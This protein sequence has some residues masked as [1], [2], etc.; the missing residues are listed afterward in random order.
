MKGPDDGERRAGCRPPVP[1]RPK[2]QARSTECSHTL[3]TGAGPRRAATSWSARY[4]APADAATLD[5]FKTSELVALV[6]HAMAF[7]QEKPVGAPKV[8]VRPLSGDTRRAR[9]PQRGHAVPAR[10]RL[11]RVARARPHDRPRPASADQDRRTA[12]GTLV[13]IAG[14]GDRSWSDGRQESYIAV[15]L[16]AC[17]PAR[18]RTIAGV[19][20]RHPRRC[21]H[22]RR[23][24]EAHAR[25]PAQG[26]QR[27]RGGAGQRSRSHERNEAIAF[28]EWLEAGNITLLG[29]RDYRLDGDMQTGELA[30]DRC[31]GPWPARRIQR[32]RC[33]AA[34]P[35]FVAMTPEVRRFFFEPAP[36]IIT[37][38]NVVSRIHRRVHMDY[39]GVKTLRRRRAS[40]R[41]SCASSA[42]SRRTAYTQS[43]RRDS[44]SCGTRSRAC[45]QRVGSSAES[46]AGKALINVLETFPRDEL[47]QISAG[48]LAPLDGG[49]PRS[50]AEAARA[51][52]CRAS[53][54]STASSRCCCSCRATATA[55]SVRE[56]IGDYLAEA[57]KG[58]VTAFFP[59]FHG[60]AAGA[61]PVHHRT[62]RGRR[63]RASMSRQ[64]ERGIAGIVRTWSDQLAELLAASW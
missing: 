28:L 4:S 47:F 14:A 56:R 2:P 53:I 25:A 12:D 49:H 30:A 48:R 18:T 59:V 22:R 32:C 27:S 6:D 31:R 61:C 29:M 64:L 17:R 3:K 15:H 43:P 54:A 41:A 11:R 63:R 16:D 19:V 9:D 62:P 38:S 36:L 58:H 44:R 5:A 42:S 37:K 13:R 20:G 35:N 51:R 52:V 39:I 7:L 1:A 26:H 55:R 50:G 34:A 23:R 33:C 10:Q 57:Y 40:R 24:L 60:R 45:L 46:H 8:A 21:P